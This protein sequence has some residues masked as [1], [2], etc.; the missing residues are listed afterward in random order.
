MSHSKQK[1][2]SDLSKATPTEGEIALQQATAVMLAGAAAASAPLSELYFAQKIGEL[3]EKLKGTGDE[4]VKLRDKLK[5]FKKENASMSGKIGAL[6][7]D[8]HRQTETIRSLEKAQ[9]KLQKD[10]ETVNKA[11]DKLRIEVE[12]KNSKFNKENEILLEKLEAL[13]KDFAAV[14]N[15]NKDLKRSLE[16]LKN[17]NTRLQTRVDSIEQENGNL[18][19]EM[20]ELRKD[21]NKIQEQLDRKEMRLALGQVAWLLEAEIW[22]NV[23]PDIAMGKTRILNSMERWL[24]RNGEKEEGKA[25][26]NRWD[27]L[28]SKLNWDEDDHRSALKILKDLRVADAHPTDVDLEEASK[29]LMEGGYIA[30]PDKE[31]CQQIIGMVKTTKSLNQDK[32]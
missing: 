28:K 9:E 10:L 12:E 18:Q 17:D 30:D 29:Q 23:L 21:H 20:G 24:K 11:K 22:K 15:E 1:K 13:T 2:S 5:T 7:K 31:F 25:A 4:N 19:N 27:E 14:E 32:E 26:Q 6:E 8:N 16:E 3:T